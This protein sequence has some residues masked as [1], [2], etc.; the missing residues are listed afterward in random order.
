VVDWEK[1]NNGTPCL[2]CSRR[3]KFL[4]LHTETKDNKRLVKEGVAGPI[5]E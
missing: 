3:G 5:W 2:L 4:I 1:T